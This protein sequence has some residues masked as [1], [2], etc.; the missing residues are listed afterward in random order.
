MEK[1]KD[2]EEDLRPAELPEGQNLCSGLCWNFPF[3]NHRP[4]PPTAIPQQTPSVNR[5]LR[6]LPLDFLLKAELLF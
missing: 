5:R 4:G 6:S 1:R 3:L 2:A